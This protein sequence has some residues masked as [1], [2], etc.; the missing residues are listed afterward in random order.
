MAKKAP[1]QYGTGSIYKDPRNP[2]RLIGEIVLDGRRRRV[3]GSTKTEVTAKLRDL[4]VKAATGTLTD[5]KKRITVADATETFMARVVPNMTHNGR[6]LSPSTLETYR[7]CAGLITDELGAKKVDALT[8]EDVEAMLDRLQTKGLAKASLWKVRSKLGQILDTARRRKHV[9]E[10]VARDAELPA[11]AAPAVKRNALQ[12]EDARKLL[13][14]LQG[15]RN[16]LMYGLSLL[17]GLRPG[18]AAGLFWEDVDLDAEPPTVNVT[19]GVQLDRGMAS[20]SDELKTSES[21]R[22]IELPVNVVQW[23]RSHRLDQRKERLAA[24]RWLDDRLVFA[25]PNG[26][27]IDPA[28]ARKLLAAVCEDAG[29]PDTRP[30]ELRHSCASLLAD[31]GVPNE[32]IADLLGHTTTRMVDSTYRHRLRPVVSVA[33]DKMDA[34]FGG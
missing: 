21:K 11:N 15:T 5:R 3:S 24:H 17:L 14:A 23:F 1:R 34:L 7:W 18:E 8:V 16:G 25:S 10:N 22:T 6:P 13:V 28:N 32:A 33:A 12:P 4:Q 30:N 29:V 26:H 27:I 31:E 20:I 9:T 2:K 19:R